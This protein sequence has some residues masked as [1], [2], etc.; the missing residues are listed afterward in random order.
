MLKFVTYWND[1]WLAHAVLATLVTLAVTIES[2]L[3]SSPTF[4][5]LS[6]ALGTDWGKWTHDLRFKFAKIYCGFAFSN[7]LARQWTNA[8]ADST[9]GVGNNYSLCI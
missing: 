4:R 6:L 9:G 5:T 2:N 7:T 8:F 1:M 3:H